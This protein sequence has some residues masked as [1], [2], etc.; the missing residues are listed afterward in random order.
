M[1]TYVT[2]NWKLRLPC[3]IFSSRMS[4]ISDNLLLRVRHRS[5][6]Y[7]VF[8]ASTMFTVI[9][10]LPHIYLQS[11]LWNAQTLTFWS[12][13][14][15]LL[16][17]AAGSVLQHAGLDG[18]QKK[19]LSK[20]VRVQLAGWATESTLHSTAEWFKQINK[21]LPLQFSPTSSHLNPTETT[22]MYR[23]LQW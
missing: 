14:G 18:L 21:Q 19:L 8:S 22:K 3:V 20:S 12:S 15:V 2:I 13:L 1:I 5:K 7:S 4:H 11:S 10:P 23:I 6:I 16:Q 9:C 17:P